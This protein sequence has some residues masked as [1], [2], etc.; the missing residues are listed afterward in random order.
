MKSRVVHR[1]GMSHATGDEVRDGVAAQSA[2][3]AA[4]SLQ[5]DTRFISKG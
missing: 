3:I 5:R 2:L 1:L 4:D